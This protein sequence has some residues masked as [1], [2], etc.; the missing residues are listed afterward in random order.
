MRALEGSVAADGN[1][2]AA[3]ISSEAA[4]T[5]IATLPVLELDRAITV[6]RA[7]VVVNVVIATV[8]LGDPAGVV[9]SGVVGAVA[10]GGRGHS[11]RAA[12]DKYQRAGAD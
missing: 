4:V 10:R 3:R 12:A 8:V 7:A 9:V 1:G 5:A 11:C 2:E 6:A